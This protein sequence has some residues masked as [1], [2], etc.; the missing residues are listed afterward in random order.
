MRKIYC[1]KCG[2]EVNPSELI[3][4]GIDFKPFDL[5]AEP[6]RFDICPECAAKFSDWLKGKCACQKQ[7]KPVYKIDN[8]QSIKALSARYQTSPRKMNTI[9]AQMH[10]ERRM[11]K[12]GVNW[13]YEYHITAEISQ[14]LTKK[15]NGGKK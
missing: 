5:K 14:K 8:W 13:W 2:K 9:M 6:K 15:L 7:D 12:D 1:D 4:F 3:K 10:V 11:K